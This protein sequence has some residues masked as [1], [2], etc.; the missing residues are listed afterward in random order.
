MV[1]YEDYYKILGVSR[2]ASDAEIK[3]AYRKL[4]RQYHPDNHPD[5]K[6]AEEKFKKINQ[7]YEILSDPQK[8]SQYE[9][10]GQMP[11]GSEF[12]PP[13]GFN[14]GG[15]VRGDFADLFEM[16]FSGGQANSSVFAG[17]NFPFPGG[18]NNKGQDVRSHIKLSL[19]EAFHGT[20]KRLTLN[21]T[22]EI[23]VKIPPGVH[24]GT[25]IRLANKGG[26][27][28]FGGARGD[29]LLEVK[30]Y[31]HSLFTLT[32]DNIE[33]KEKISITEAV[34]GG[35]KIVDT[36]DGKIELRVPA[37]IQGGQKLRLSGKGWQK[38]KDSGRGDHLI[39]IAIQIPQHLS[40]KQRSIFEQ[41]RESGL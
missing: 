37:G 38:R 8:R 27:S 2:N 23:E 16:L 15:N 22:E 11:H 28:Q 3:K 6:L 14:F 18:T 13:P 29:L 41:L 21:Y 32:G 5:K 33:S 19:E 10:L 12:R 30:L 4:A 20:N 34:F 26:I 35:I 36:L 17:G 9:Q 1:A 24:E 31:P 25:V 7:A 40:E 39:Q